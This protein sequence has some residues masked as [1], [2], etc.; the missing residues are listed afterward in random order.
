M[1]RIFRERGRSG[2]AEKP[3]AG[4]RKPVAEGPKA[5]VPLRSG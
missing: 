3:R 5:C 1:T 2:K 4:H